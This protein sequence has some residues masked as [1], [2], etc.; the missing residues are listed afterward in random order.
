MADQQLNIRLDAIDNTKKV[1]N[2]LQNNLKGV[3]KETDNTTTSFFTLKNAIIGVFTSAVVKQITDTTKSLQEF[4]ANIITAVGSVEQGAETFRYLTEFSK[5]TQFGIEDLARSFL[6]L[7]QN[8]VE[9]TDRMLNIFAKTAG[10]ASN[11]VD[12]LNDLTRLFAKGAQGGF[13]IMQLNQLVANGIP[14]FQILREELGLDEKSLTLLGSTAGGA[15][16]ILENLLDGL[17][18]RANK[19]I[20]PVFSLSKSFKDFYQQAQSALFLIGDQKEV[21]GFVDSLTQLLVALQPIINLIALLVQKSLQGF[22]FALQVLNPLIGFLSEFLTDLMIPIKSVADSMMQYLVKA[23]GKMAES[24]EYLRKKYKQFKESVFGEPIELKVNVDQSTPK[25]KPANFETK[26]LTPVQKT[27]QA[28]QVAT[29]TLNEQFKEIYSTIAQ[30][31]VGGIKDVS[32]ALAE[33]LILG[34]KLQTTFAD[35]ARNLLVKIIAGLIEEQ[36]AKLAL[37]ALDEIAVLL[38]LKRLSIEKEITSEKRKQTE[39]GTG[40]TTPEDIAKKQLGSIFDE[41]FNRLKTSFDDIF[42]S[43]SDIFGSISDY[44]S[45]IFSDIGSSLM[46]ILGNLG[47]SIGD[48]FNSIGGSLGDILGSIGNMFGGGGG[49]G[50]GFDMGTLFDIGMMIFGAAEGGALNAGQPYMVGERGRELFIPNQSGTMIPNHDLGTTGST[51][52][53]FTINATDVKGVQELLINNR[54]TITNL[55]N[56]A[57][58][59]RGKSNLV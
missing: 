35:I 24:I 15:K 2:D 5:K 11:K 34:K 47:S 50:G 44:S 49:G 16:L 32:R 48:I 10:N 3:N 52:I 7:Y 19:T 1:F 30:G 27:V 18:K 13:N 31:L 6:T 36:L 45:Q 59:A 39:A 57:L 55:V 43:I 20:D 51:S 41:L 22:I 12:A 25:L 46:D 9:P 4:R 53:N 21:A 37:L 28:M 17:E 38:G 29:F 8:G 54:A 33:S 14:A 56:Q 58:N 26:D 40:T 42:G 23:F